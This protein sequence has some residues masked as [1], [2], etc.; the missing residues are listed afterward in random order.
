LVIRNKKKIRLTVQETNYDCGSAAVRMLLSYYNYNFTKKNLKKLLLTNNTGTDVIN[1][2]NFLVKELGLTITEYQDDI[3]KAKEYLNK[4][5]PLLICYNI[6]GM[7]QYS[8]YA[9]VVGY[10]RNK[11]HILNPNSDNQNQIFE[12]YDLKWFKYWWKQE[13]YWFLVI[14]K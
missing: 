1:I 8:H 6:L 9:L 4:N 2:R 7:E 3:K 5:I 11:I 10:E 13:K 14:E 12:T